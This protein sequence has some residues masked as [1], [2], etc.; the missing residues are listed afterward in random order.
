MDSCV[1]LFNPNHVKKLVHKN[2]DWKEIDDPGNNDYSTKM[3]NDQGLFVSLF[4]SVLY[5][6]S[7]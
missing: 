5:T 3:D 2:K 1:I 6:F 4:F 7:K